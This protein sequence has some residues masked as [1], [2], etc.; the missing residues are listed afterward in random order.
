MEAQGGLRVILF[1]CVGGQGG[2]VER[3]EYTVFGADTH[4]VVAL[5]LGLG[6]V[7]SVEVV[8]LVLDIELFEGA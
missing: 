7:G 2:G 4:F 1:L 3:E 5:W 8:L 6:L